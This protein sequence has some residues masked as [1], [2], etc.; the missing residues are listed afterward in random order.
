MKKSLLN[1]LV[2]PIDKQELEIKIFQIDSKDEIKEGLLSCTHCRRY[3][4]IIFGIPVM[5]PDE[6]REKSLEEPLLNKWKNQLNK[7][8]FEDF[9]L[10]NSR[11]TNLILVA[12]ELNYFLESKS[13][14]VPFFIFFDWDTLII[15][16]YLS[17]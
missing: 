9:K 7:S 1:K 15:S 10:L 6:Y 12:R 5:T 17:N 8:E 11:A 14:F 16:I 13:Q 4:P 3:Y 2:C